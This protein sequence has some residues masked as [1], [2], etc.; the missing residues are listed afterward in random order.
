M[1]I[2]PVPENPFHRVL[3]TAA[4]TR[5]VDFM[6]SMCVSVALITVVSTLLY[7]ELNLLAFV[8]IFSTITTIG[9]FCIKCGFEDNRTVYGYDVRH[10]ML[11]DANDDP[12]ISDLSIEG[13]SDLSMMSYSTDDSGIED[14]SLNGSALL[15]LIEP[16][17]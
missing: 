1:D 12:F 7:F 6:I 9:L 5:F 11:G 15:K 17:E 4:T 13:L 10:M 2:F 14:D 8:T 16:E 3:K